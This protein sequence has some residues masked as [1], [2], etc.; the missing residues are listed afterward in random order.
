M[1][2]RKEIK[3]KN[4]INKMGTKRTIQKIN[5]VELVP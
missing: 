1:R 2:G 5:E 4:E 3:F